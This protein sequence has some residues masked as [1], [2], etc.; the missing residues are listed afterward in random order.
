[1]TEPSIEYNKAVFWVKIGRLVSVGW[2]AFVGICVLAWPSIAWYYTQDI[3][4]LVI[5]YGCYLALLLFGAGIALHER[6]TD[7]RVALSK[8]GPMNSIFDPLP[9]P[10][11]A[12]VIEQEKREV[13]RKNKEWEEN[14]NKAREARIVQAEVYHSPYPPDHMS[15]YR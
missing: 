9:D 1:V 8:H 2:W 10:K 6:V 12:S 4:I 5:P 14:Q 11:S 7:S 15:P 3:K 13:E